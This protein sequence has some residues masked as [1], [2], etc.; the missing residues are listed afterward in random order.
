ME[1]HFP[2]FQF[3]FSVDH[4]I[5][6][7]EVQWVDYLCVNQRKKNKKSQT[8][9]APLTRSREK[10]LL[11]NNLNKRITF[12]FEIYPPPVVNS[13]VSVSLRVKHRFKSKGR[14]FDHPRMAL[15]SA[16]NS[17]DSVSASIMCVHMPW[18]WLDTQDDIFIGQRIQLQNISKENVRL[19]IHD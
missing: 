6:I 12:Y 15:D 14:C 18:Y 5:R 13:H 10:P 2:L 3:I 9:I 1:F 8:T 16:N 17:G 4:D 19:E 11:E 7:P